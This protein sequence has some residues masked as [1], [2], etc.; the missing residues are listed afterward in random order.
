MDWLRTYSEPTGDKTFM[1]SP[2]NNPAERANEQDI[3]ITKKGTSVETECALEI[4]SLFM[5]S[6]CK[7][8]EEV[9]QVRNPVLVSIPLLDALAQEIVFAR[10]LEDRREALLYIIRPFAKYGLLP[11]PESSSG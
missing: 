4:L 8:I 2:T 6:V 7:Y 11:E 5:L 1:F 3:I 9:R 10:L